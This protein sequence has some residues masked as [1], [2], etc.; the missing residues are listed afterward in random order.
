MQR[1]FLVILSW[2]LVNSFVLSPPDVHDL[3]ALV[4]PEWSCSLQKFQGFQGHA[5]KFKSLHLCRVL[6]YKP[7][8]VLIHFCFPQKQLKAA[9]PSAK[10]LNKT[11][12]IL[13]KFKG[14]YMFSQTR[15]SMWIKQNLCLC[16]YVGIKMKT[17]QAKGSNKS[18]VRLKYLQKYCNELLS[19][20]QQVSQSAVLIR[21]FQAKDQELQ[22]EFTK[23]RFNILI[24][25]SKNTMERIRSET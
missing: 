20:D 23:N 8:V 9:F 3:R 12:R 19:C 21:F 11:D 6:L 13:P 22:P 24:W 16:G 14:K 5:R 2:S 25:L 7:H 18:L 4:R 15:D 1:V 17:S 10:K